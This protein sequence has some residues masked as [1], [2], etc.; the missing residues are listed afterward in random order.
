MWLSSAEKAEKKDRQFNIQGVAEDPARRNLAFWSMAFFVLSAFLASLIAHGLIKRYLKA[1]LV[2][3]FGFSVA[4]LIGYCFGDNFP[5]PLLMSVAVVAKGLLALLVALVVG[6][7]F[8][9][10]RQ[11]DGKDE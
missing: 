8:L 3:G 11:R 10:V 4:S 5:V 1:A 9:H 6:L 2:I 7:P